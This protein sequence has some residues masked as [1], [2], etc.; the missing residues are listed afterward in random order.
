MSIKYVLMLCSLYPVI[1]L[2]TSVGRIT[3]VALMH[4]TLDFLTVDQAQQDWTPICH[5]FWDFAALCILQRLCQHP[6]V[7]QYHLL[8]DV[9]QCRNPKTTFSLIFFHCTRIL[10]LKVAERKSISYTSLCVLLVPGKGPCRYSTYRTCKAQTESPKLTSRVQI[11][12]VLAVRYCCSTVPPSQSILQTTS[13]SY[14]SSQTT[15]RQTWLPSGHSQ[16]LW[17]DRHFPQAWWR[18]KQS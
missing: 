17:K 12:N 7:D 6:Q 16:T 14:W 10:I 13:R 8:H 18:P 5:I 9:A 1:T 11:R 2:F 3:V 4:L 15:H